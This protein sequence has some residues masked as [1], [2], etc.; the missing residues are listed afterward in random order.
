MIRLL[1]V[2]YVPVRTYQ[3][4]R[5]VRSFLVNK[6]LW[7]LYKQQ[8]HVQG[9]IQ[10]PWQMGC[11]HREGS[12]SRIKRVSEL[13]DKSRVACV[14]GDPAWLSSRQVASPRPRGLQQVRLLSPSPSPGVRSDSCPSSLQ[15]CLTISSSVTLGRKHPM[16]EE[17]MLHL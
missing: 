16:L 11:W 7:I 8:I 17:Q 2:I 13:S 9:L 15:G 5:D 14:L 4:E 3:G 1:L 6:N 12:P 10:K